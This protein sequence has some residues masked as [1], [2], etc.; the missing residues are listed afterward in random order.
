MQLLPLL[1]NVTDTFLLQRDA[2]RKRGLCCSPVSVRLFDSQ[3]RYQ[4]PKGTP[5]EGCK[6]DKGGNILRF[7]TQIAI[8]LRNGTR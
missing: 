4:I 3:R 8:Y 1:L 2:M 7:S 5:S 6:I